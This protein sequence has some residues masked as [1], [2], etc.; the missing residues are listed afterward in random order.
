[1][2][3]CPRGLHDM[4]ALTPDGQPGRATN[5]ACRMCK[6]AYNMRYQQTDK[7]RALTRAA[8]VRYNQSDRGRALRR[9]TDERYNQSYKGLLNQMSHGINR[10]RG[11]SV[12]ALVESML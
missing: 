8:H 6:R 11:R 9:A 1:M 5:G 7:G 12:A 4:G 3:P 10:R 2:S